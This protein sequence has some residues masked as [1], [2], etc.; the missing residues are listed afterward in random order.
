MA[1]CH[2][3]RDQAG[4]ATLPE[5]QKDLPGV[6]CEACQGPGS[7]YKSMTIMKSREKST[8]AGLI[9]PTE[10]TC[11]ACHNSKSP[12]FKSFNYAE[13]VKKVHDKKTK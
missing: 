11:T 12:H 4:H 8:A 10:K 9:L 2:G 13:M 6:E 7:D 1:S 5:A 3:R